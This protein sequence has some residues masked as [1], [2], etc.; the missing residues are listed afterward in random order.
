MTAATGDPEA[1]RVHDYF[2][3]GEADLSGLSDEEATTP[4]Q[5]LTLADH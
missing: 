3:S 2:A 4:R 5:R 1:R